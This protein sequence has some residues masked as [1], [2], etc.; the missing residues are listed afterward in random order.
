MKTKVDRQLSG[1]AVEA[2][3]PSDGIGK[4]VRGGEAAFERRGD[5]ASAKWFGEEEVVARAQAGFGE[6]LVILDNTKGD[7]TELGFIILD[8]VPAGNDNASFAS[9]FGSTTYD[10]LGEVEREGSGEGGDVEGKN[11]PSAH[12]VNVRK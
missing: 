7:E 11:R 6:N 1:V 12:G 3:H 10:G 8:G 9:F 4:L 5:D 2:F